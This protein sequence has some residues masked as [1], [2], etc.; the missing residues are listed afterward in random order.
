MD[1]KNVKNAN[2][3]HFMTNV[4][5]GHTLG[6]CGNVEMRYAN[7]VSGGEGS[8]VMAKLPDGRQAHTALLFMVFEN[9]SAH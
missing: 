3:T 4:D 1:E 6:F 9:V 2:E 7:V 8:I 5:N